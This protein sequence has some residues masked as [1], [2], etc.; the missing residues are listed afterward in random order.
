MRSCLNTFMVVGLISILSLGTALAKDKAKAKKEHR[1]H[2]AHSHGAGKMSIAF[3]GLKG[4]IELE[5]AADS[6]LGFEHEAKTDADKATLAKAYKNFQ[7]DF[8]KMVLF[9]AASEC[10]I[11]ADKIE[12]KSEGQKSKHSD[13]KASYN[14]ECKKTLLNTTVKFNFAQY[15]NIHDLDVTILVD[16]LQKNIEISNKESSVV[17]K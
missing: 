7:N 1:H 17:L 10:M 8:G 14:V 16:Q 12:Q 2:H 4:R 13:F 3:D 5:L 15:Q 11:T 9:D 6:I